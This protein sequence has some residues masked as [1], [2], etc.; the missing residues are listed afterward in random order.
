[1][2][3]DSPFFI[4]LLRSTITAQAAWSAPFSTYGLF[5]EEMYG[6]VNISAASASFQHDTR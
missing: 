4:T 2:L 6:T 1:M 3:G 5:R